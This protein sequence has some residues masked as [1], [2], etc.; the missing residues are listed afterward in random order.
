MELEINRNCV[1]KLHNVS[2]SLKTLAVKIDALIDDHLHH[3]T[4]YKMV[5]IDILKAIRLESG[6]ISIFLSNA[7]KPDGKNFESNENR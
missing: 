5:S 2:T 1:T 6:A 7:S 3:R 4:P